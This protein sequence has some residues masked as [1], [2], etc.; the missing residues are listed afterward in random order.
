[1]IYDNRHF[2][3]VKFGSSFGFVVEKVVFAF[4]QEIS[5]SFFFTTVTAGLS[6]TVLL[7]KPTALDH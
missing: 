3:K 5:P 1:M 6:N 2:K 4:F 7:Q